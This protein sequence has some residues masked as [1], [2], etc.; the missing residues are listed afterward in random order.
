MYF[1]GALRITWDRTADAAYVYLTQEQLPAGLH[2]V[3]VDT[4]ADVPGMVLLDFKGGRLVGVEVLNASQ[5]L[6][7]DLLAKAVTID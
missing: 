5:V 6:H 3:Q 7:P 2:T 4:P 1:E